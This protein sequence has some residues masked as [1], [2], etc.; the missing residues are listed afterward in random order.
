VNA[1]RLARL[2]IRVCTP[3]NRRDDTLGDLEETYRARVAGGSGATRLH[4]WMT[5]HV[6]AVLIAAAMVWQRGRHPHPT[7][8]R[9]AVNST[10]VRLGLRL[11]YRQ[12]VLTMTAVVALAAG[13]A[14][15]TVGFAFMD[16]LLYSRLPFA[17][18]E[19]FVTLQAY[20]QPGGTL[21]S[22]TSH[23]VAALATQTTRLE[24]L[25]GL[26]G[27]RDNVTLPSGETVV[28]TT[29]GLTPSTFRYLPVRPVSGRLFSRDDGRPGG[30]PVVVVR[31]G[32]W[33]A[34]MPAPDGAIGATVTVG[35]RAHTVIGVAPDS[36]EF[37]NAPDVWMPLDEGVVSGRSRA[38]ADLRWLG[39]LAPGQT[40]DTLQRQLDEVS[41]ALPA[42][43]P[44]SPTTTIRVEATGFTDLGRMGTN[45]SA[46]TVIVVVAVLF[47]I[48]ANVGNLILARSF[49]R[50]REFSLRSALGASRTQL[51]A[52]VTLE[53]LFIAGVAATIGSIGA[54]AVLRLLNGMDELPF[55]VDFTGGTRTRVLVVLATM[56]AVAVAGAWPAL[57]ATNRRVSAGVEG[58]GGRASDVR[59]GRMAG[60][61]VVT[62]IAISIVMLHGALVVAQ[63]FDR[64]TGADLDL[65]RNVVTTYMG[66][67][68]ASVTA[69]DLERWLT[70][71]PGVIAVG[72]GTALPRHSPH[73]RRVELESTG[74]NP[75][76]NLI[77]GLAPEVEVTRG[78]FAALEATSLAGR[79][80][81]PQDFLPGARPVA[82][83]NAP[84]VQ[85]FLGGGAAVGRRFRTVESGTHG[86]W[87]EIV[88]VV[89]DLGLNVA[90][91]TLAASFYVPLRADTSAV[92]LALRVSGDPLAFAA[93]LRRALLAHD[94][95]TVVGRVQLLEDEAREDRDFFKWFSVALL[96]LGVITLILALA[97]VYAMM[98]LIVTRRTREIGV[99][100]A[101]GATAGRIVRSVVGRTAWQVG[102]GGAVGCGLALVSLELR[103]VLVSRMGDG[104][105]WTLPV[106]MAVLVT[107]GLAATWLPL[108][109]ALKIQAADALRS[110]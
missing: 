1:P 81:T 6:D 39:I 56:G 49:A 78:Y 41:A 95:D 27:S 96:A 42:S 108:R 74:T 10:D 88:G 36:F 45:L 70:D 58:G 66:V 65:P 2:L 9:H 80:L 44:A 79:L 52:Q 13:I 24:H 14:L 15:A 100:M 71:V 8:L 17:G 91:E 12:P 54:S 85:T 92:Y 89:P 105:T 76:E 51:V 75:G 107:S 28:A 35:G 84:F 7:N 4:V 102:L 101:L 60:A 53:V 5:T 50:A 82:V 68:A 21:V 97:G 83:V 67:N 43:A 37:P 59:F 18:G 29:A 23:D 61:M 73:A 46:A 16:A 31:E 19:R 64:F 47:V 106:V 22:L 104:G 103:T 98:S 72:A 26:S 57:R 87:T 62:Q 40:V 20:E 110:E 33:R 11:M 48:A 30:A 3:A 32:F 93:P 109:R 69:H 63:A 77:A 99:R 86:Q 38:A 55:W 94:P 25:G 90:D 34:L